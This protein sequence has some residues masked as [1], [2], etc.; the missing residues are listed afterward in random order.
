MKR[1]FVKLT[2]L[3]LLVVGVGASAAPFSKPP[4][5]CKVTYDAKTLI[6]FDADV[7]EEVATTKSQAI[8]GVDLIATAHVYYS[9]EL[10]GFRWGSKGVL[11]VS[12][13]VR[14]DVG[15]TATSA[16]FSLTDPNTITRAH[17]ADF[18]DEKP[19]DICNK[20]LADRAYAT[21]VALNSNKDSV[22]RYPPDRREATI[23]FS[24]PILLESCK[25]Y[26]A[27]REKNVISTSRIVN[28]KSLVLECREP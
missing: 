21:E 26:L 1:S 20:A 25:S 6:E 13:T 22:D 5:Q 17:I 15:R 3:C 8:P 23:K 2:L 18:S 11:D 27:N 24:L 16:R 14:L 4:S 19:V 9:D 7:G 12:T 10:F 28:G